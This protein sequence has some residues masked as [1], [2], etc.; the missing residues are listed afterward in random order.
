LNVEAEATPE[1]LETA[2]L[3]C[4]NTVRYI[5]DFSPSVASPDKKVVAGSAG[6]FTKAAGS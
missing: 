2:C 6:Q 4:P 5:I 3:Y 1:I